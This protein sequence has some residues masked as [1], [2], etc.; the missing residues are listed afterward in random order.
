MLIITLL[1]VDRHKLTVFYLKSIVV[2]SVQWE[3]VVVPFY[4]CYVFSYVHCPKSLLKPLTVNNTLN[5]IFYLAF[6]QKE[7]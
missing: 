6:L 2:D 1:V 3:I 4:R 5:M 7:K